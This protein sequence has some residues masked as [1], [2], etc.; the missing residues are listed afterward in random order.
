MIVWLEI[1]HFR[2]S[3]QLQ[4]SDTVICLTNCLIKIT[5]SYDKRVFNWF[6][7][8]DI[9]IKITCVVFELL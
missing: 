3:L 5:H 9:G 6:G 8:H 7:E 4:P 1:Y 2:P